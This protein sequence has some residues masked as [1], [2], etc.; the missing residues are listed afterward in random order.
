MINNINDSYITCFFNEE[1][2]DFMDHKVNPNMKMFSRRLCVQ[3]PHESF[4]IEDEFKLDTKA[5]SINDNPFKSSKED[6]VAN[7]SIY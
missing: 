2:N 7:V 6:N 5:G 4:S 1:W 3:E